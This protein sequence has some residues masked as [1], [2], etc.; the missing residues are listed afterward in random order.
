MNKRKAHTPAEVAE[1]LAKYIAKQEDTLGRFPVGPMANTAKMNL[2][3]ASAA[4]EKLKQ[5]NEQMKQLSDVRDR[6]EQ[7]GRQQAMPKMELGTETASAGESAPDALDMSLSAVPTMTPAQKMYFQQLRTNR[8]L[9]PDAALAVVSVTAKESNGAMNAV[10]GSTGGKYHLTDWNKIWSEGHWLGKRLREVYGNNEAQAKRLWEQSKQ[11]GSDEPILNVAYNGRAGNNQ[12]GDGWKYRGRGLIQLTGRENYKR[13]GEYMHAQ[14]LVD[15]PDYFLEN[16]DAIVEDSNLGMSAVDWYLFENGTSITDYDGVPDLTG[17]L[18]SGDIGAVLDA[19]YAKVA[20]ANSLSAAR[21][22]NLYDNGMPKMR[23]WLNQ[24]RVAASL[25]EISFQDYDK[26]YEAVSDIESDIRS[27]LGLSADQ[28]IGEAEITQY[29]QSLGMPIEKID[30]QLG[31]ITQTYAARRQY[32]DSLSE[33]AERA[34][35]VEQLPVNA[36]NKAAAMSENTS[37]DESTSAASPRFDAMSILQGALAN[38]KGAQEQDLNRRG[39]S[40]NDLKAGRYGNSEVADLGADAAA[41]RASILSDTELADKLIPSVGQSRSNPL[42][43]ARYGGSVKKLVE[44]G[45]TKEEIMEQLMLDPE[46]QAFMQRNG[47]STEQVLK[48]ISGGYDDNKNATA[49]NQRIRAAAKQLQ[50]EPEKRP[51]RQ[52]W[53][54][55]VLS[56]GGSQ[57]NPNPAASDSEFEERVGMSRKSYEAAY[58]DAA[59]RNP[60]NHVI[61]YDPNSEKFGAGSTILEAAAVIADKPEFMRDF[62]G[63]RGLDEMRYDIS[64]QLG[65]EGAREFDEMINTIHDQPTAKRIGMATMAALLAGS[66]V[67]AAPLLGAALAPVGSIGIGS[68]G[69]TVGG[70][71]NAGMNAYGAYEAANML[72]GFDGRRTV[73]DII[74]DRNASFEEKLWTAAQLGLNAA[75]VVGGALKFGRGAAGLMTGNSRAVFDY[76]RS[77]ALRGAGYQGLDDA[78]VLGQ[79]FNSAQQGRVAAGLDVA[80]ASQRVKQAK[81]VLDDLEGLGIGSGPVAGRTP[82]MEGRLAAARQELAAAE[83]AYNTALTTQRSLKAQQLNAQ[84]AGESALASGNAVR[85]NIFDDGALQMGRVTGAF[86]NAPAKGAPATGLLADMFGVDNATRAISEEVKR[87]TGVG[88]NLVFDGQGNVFDKNGNPVTPGG[89]PLR[90]PNRI[91]VPANILYEDDLAAKSGDI[92][93]GQK[94]MTPV[95]PDQSPG[96]S[97]GTGY[98]IPPGDV[99]N[100]QMGNMSPL[101]AIPGLAAMNSARVQREALGKMEGPA[102]PEELGIRQFDYESNVGQQMADIQASTNAMSRNTNLSS[103]AAAAN[104]QGLLAQRFGMQN[105]VRA[106]DQQMRT[107]A[108]MSYDTQADAVRNANNVMRNR[109]TQDQVDFKN[110]MAQLEAS[111]KQQPMSVL[112]SAAQDYLQNVYANNQQLA[113]AQLGRFYD[114]SAPQNSNS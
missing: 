1:K 104:R 5:A 34:G 94:Q 90:D 10:E 54:D 31:N 85:Q 33:I 93:D 98:D 18:G 41:A 113:L 91:G 57:E 38:V 74:S 92:L 108:R 88:G 83:E 11:Q 73:G 89:V 53:Q 22:R 7:Y 62:F 69:L 16:P 49:L 43:E 77:T 96:I 59:S 81:Q 112:S 28:P 60:N 27:K 66:A 35:G 111:V 84:G 26:S 6:S 72:G 95:T 23:E 114:T 55:W 105:Q 30:G 110:K 86:T 82:A 8:G 13:L 39:A 99:I 29:Q 102:R 68:T 48:I 79:R 24:T 64:Q 42:V 12:T 21:N 2:Q 52:P 58:K 71:A 15:S 3:K 44:G 56:N 70:I 78:Y 76:A 47:Y 14:G 51:A 63:E 46:F 32:E 17:E 87:A 80:E 9:S 75:P 50:P 65:E 19:T 67:A 107:Q 36:A 40:F 4:M 109:F 25:P 106:Q 101:M 100:L 20:G 45:P 103:G 97:P 37:S 61:V